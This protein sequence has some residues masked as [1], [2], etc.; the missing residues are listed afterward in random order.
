MQWGVKNNYKES[1]DEYYQKFLKEPTVETFDDFSL[2]ITKNNIFDYAFTINKHSLEEIAT[3]VESECILFNGRIAIANAYLGQGDMSE[4]YN[5]YCEAMDSLSAVVEDLNETPEFIEKFTS[6]DLDK[7]A[8]QVKES[9]ACCKMLVDSYK[10]NPKSNEVGT[11]AM[12]MVDY[13]TTLTNFAD[14][15]SKNANSI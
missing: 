6:S 5:A 4:F 8:K 13:L 10:K 11:Y 15:V 3:F 1:L 12:Q 14:E 7:I 2:Y 9:T